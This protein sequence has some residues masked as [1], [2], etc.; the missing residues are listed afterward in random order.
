MC[1]QCVFV[2]GMNTSKANIHKELHD[3]YSRHMRSSL[4]ARHFLFL[5]FL[6]LG[7]VRYYSQFVQS[8]Y[9]WYM[10]RSTPPARTQGRFARCGRTTLSAV[11]VHV[12]VCTFTVSV[13]LLHTDP[14]RANPP[15]QEAAYDPGLVDG[16]AY[17]AL[18]AWLIR[19]PPKISNR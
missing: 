12:H 1:E 18:H 11:C 10:A 13:V 17:Y 9:A 16:M 19:Y 8:A 15:F 14:C 2:I 6:L 5:L 3:T 4:A 7:H